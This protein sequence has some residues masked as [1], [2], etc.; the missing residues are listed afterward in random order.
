MRDI[1]ILLN[2]A[3]GMKKLDCVVF[4]SIAEKVI[5]GETNTDGSHDPYKLTFVLE[6]IDDRAVP[7][8]TNRYLN[9]RK[10]KK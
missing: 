3:E 1:R 5:V 4:E 7:D 6:G 8:A 9:L 2:E 10:K